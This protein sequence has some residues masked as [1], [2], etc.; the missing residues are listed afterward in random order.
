MSHDFSPQRSF[1]GP[2]FWGRRSHQQ[3][4]PAAPQ[5]TMA[6]SAFLARASR[7]STS[8]SS[9]VISLRS[10]AL[11]PAAANPTRGQQTRALS[12]SV[13]S[14]RRRPWHA[15]APS[16]AKNVPGGLGSVWSLQLQQTRGMKVHSSIKRRCEH[17]KVSPSSFHIRPGWR[18]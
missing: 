3:N 2:E 8:V 9:L 13:L 7:T 18:A 15:P 4:R 16:L 17:C 10:L 14:M 6:A 1:G 5:S 11:S 12:Q